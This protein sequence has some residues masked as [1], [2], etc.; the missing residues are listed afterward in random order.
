MQSREQ[1]YACSAELPSMV[2]A[3]SLGREGYLGSI[4][5]IYLM[6][7]DISTKR[8][9]ILSSKRDKDCQS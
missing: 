3:S 4:R 6:L 5:E 1:A 7:P 8:R 2:I 9:S